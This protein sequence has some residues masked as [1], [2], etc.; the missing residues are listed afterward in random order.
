MVEENSLNWSQWW[1]LA[2]ITLNTLINT[3]VFFR[4]R[5]R[6]SKNEKG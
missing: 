6:G 3:I 5:F 1:I 4:H 2:M